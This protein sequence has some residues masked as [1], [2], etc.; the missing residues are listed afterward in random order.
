MYI[1]QRTARPKPLPA[2]A[3]YLLQG[4]TTAHVFGD[5]LVT[6]LTSSSSPRIEQPMDITTVKVKPN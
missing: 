2:Q 6:T 5:R 3:T 4:D 1:I